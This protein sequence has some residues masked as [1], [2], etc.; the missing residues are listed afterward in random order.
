M[1]EHVGMY[2]ILF[3]RGDPEH[4]ADVTQLYHAGRSLKQ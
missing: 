3:G 4:Q 2:Y 1:C